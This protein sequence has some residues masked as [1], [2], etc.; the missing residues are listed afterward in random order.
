MPDQV[1][2]AAS[3]GSSAVRPAA[4]WTRAH[5]A[6]IGLDPSRRIPL[7]TSWDVQ[8]IMPGVDFWDMWP[9]QR[10]DGTIARFDGVELWMALSAPALADPAGRHDIARI[11]LLSLKGGAYRDCGDVLP[12]EFSPGSRE[13]AGSAIVDDDG[14]RVTLFFTAAGRRGEKKPSFEQRLFETSAALVRRQERPAGFGAWTLA[15]ESVIADGGDYVQTSID[16]G[17]PGHIR[18]FRDPAYF[19]DP[20]DGAEYLLFAASLKKSQSRWNGAIGIARRDGASW[21]LCPPLLTADEL[22][23]ELERPHVIARDGAYY[24]FWSTQRHMFD[25]AGPSGPNGLYGMRAPSLF[26]PYEPLNGDGLVAGNPDEEPLQ[27]YSWLALD[28][29]EVVSFVDYWGMEGRSLALH[30]ELKR[31]RFG[32]APAPRFRI[33]LDGLRAKIG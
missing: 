3:A 17:E 19:R 22:N 8:P 10:R 33:V 21:R 23:N 15:A 31:S 12:A 26:G 1:A 5:V 28:T 13:W 32:G 9:V 25:P 2:F 20:M 24:L 11:R 27:T 14:A 30:P 7:I 29:L 6:K 16:P 18:A 4:R